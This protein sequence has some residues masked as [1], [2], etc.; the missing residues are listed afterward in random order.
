[1]FWY[2]PY[3]R[4]YGEDLS[5][6]RNQSNKV[7]GQLS[8]KADDRNVVA[9]GAA[10]PLLLGPLPQERWWDASAALIEVEVFLTQ[11]V[12]VK[13][14]RLD[15][16]VSSAARGFSAWSPSTVHVDAV[17]QLSVDGCSVTEVRIMP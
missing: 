12:F 9:T 17:G 7:P 1:L 16:R 13:A 11:P 5:S 14:A 10:R 4:S 3:L 15:P 8:N 6:P 2:S